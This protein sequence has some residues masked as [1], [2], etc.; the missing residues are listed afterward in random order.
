MANPY[1]SSNMVMREIAGHMQSG[2]FPLSDESFQ[3]P[4][5]DYLALVL[6]VADIA[7]RAA[8]LFDRE[9]PAKH[10][11]WKAELESEQYRHV[12]EREAGRINAI[13]KRQNP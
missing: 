6:T 13:E 9:P 5:R 2:G 7:E 11:N 10:G 3:E 8:Y 1:M 4:G 12:L